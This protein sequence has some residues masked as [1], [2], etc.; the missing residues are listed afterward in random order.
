MQSYQGANFWEVLFENVVSF[1]TS[2]SPWDIIQIL[3]SRKYLVDIKWSLCC[4]CFNLFNVMCVNYQVIFLAFT[5]VATC[6]L[7]WG[8]I[9]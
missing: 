7:C 8:M 5:F 2:L 9:K 4:I 6:K 1:T 3:L